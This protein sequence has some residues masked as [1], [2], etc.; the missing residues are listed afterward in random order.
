MKRKATGGAYVVRGRAYLRIS[1][2]GGRRQA[3]ALPW[4]TA[5]Q[6]AEHRGGASCSCVAC[7]RAR[8]VQ[9][10]VSRL[11][12]A[13][14]GD[15]AVKVIEAAAT[16]DDAKMTALRQAV[17][18]IVGGAIVKAAEPSP[19][20][21]PLSF[22]GFA[23]RWVRG[24]LAADY[25]DEVDRKRSAYQDLCNLTR[26]V[27][28]VVGPKL[29]RDV[30]L[31]DY[32]RALR[33]ADARRTLKARK[34]SPSTRRQIGQVMRHVLELAVYPARILTTNP[35][36]ANALPKRR[37][38][39][40]RQFVYPDE[41]ALVLR[42]TTTELGARLLVGFLHRLGLRRA[43][44]LGGAIDE[45]DEAARDEG[46]ELGDVPPLTWR[47]VDLRRG[48]ILP[49]RNK[50]SDASLIPIEADVARALAVWKRVTKASGPDDPVFTTPAGTAIAPREATT[51]YRAA[52]KRALVAADCDRP[53]L[54]TPARGQRGLRLHDARASMVTIAL[55][56][57]RT[58]DWVRRR[59]K[60]KSSAIEAYRRDLGTYRELTLG[61]WVPLDSGIPE[62][63]AA[64]DAEA[65]TVAAAST[66]AEAAASDDRL[67]DSV[68]GAR[69]FEPPTPR[70]PG[71]EGAE[72]PTTT[73]AIVGVLHTTADDGPPPQPLGAAASDDPIQ[74]L[75]RVA[76]DASAA[77]RW[78]VVEAALAEL[79]ALRVAGANVA[80]LA[81]E[82]K[83]RGRP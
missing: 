83:R 26:Y 49:D 36:P 31:D 4:V 52:V 51:I 44:V 38:P 80:D 70:P 10:L 61:D 69:G 45:V 41:D 39:P 8:D 74:R 76:A 50:T 48:Y 23:R 27:F 15:F 18:G 7:V 42:D 56:N 60:H 68:V 2:G 43:D 57:G 65:E 32:Q 20:L 55:L 13:G 34:L 73:T 59:S 54:W 35:V 25:P 53:E 1:L 58:E 46:D 29:L 47:R 5:E 66:A 3:E 9:G 79:R 12:D 11:L 30:T 64:L 75:T 81:T 19:A 14:H 16:A 82:R 78:D 33:E 62:I 24:E 28:P 77:C 6:A 67:P 40:A 37:P 21:S 22:E 71:V 17:D 63:A 72:R